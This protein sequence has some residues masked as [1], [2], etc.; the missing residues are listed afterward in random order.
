MDIQSDWKSGSLALAGLFVRTG[1]L[2]LD[3][4]SRTFPRI[5]A[6]VQRVY[7]LETV[8]QQLLRQTGA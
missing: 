6:S 7:I 3:R 1:F 4:I 2:L 8:I 5:K